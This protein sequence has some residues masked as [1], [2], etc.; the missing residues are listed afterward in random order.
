MDQIV[1]RGVSKSFFRAPEN[2]KKS[3]SQ[4]LEVLQNVNM[5]VEANEFVSVL[6]PSGCGKS[7]LLKII[8]GLDKHFAGQVE[9]D[10]RDVTKIRIPVRYM[11]QKDHLMPWRTLEQNVL[12]PV[13]LAKGNMS[14][15]RKQ[16]IT[17][18]EEFGLSGF[19]HY[20]PHE[21]SGGMKQR[22]ALLRTYLMQGDTMLLDEPFGALD[23]ITRMQMQDWLLKVWE[24]HRNTVVFVTH[25]IEEAVYLSD[26]VFVMSARPGCITRCINID[27]PRP[28]S[29]E[30][31]LETKFLD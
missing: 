16:L 10:G 17:H 26:K 11:L 22:A 19:E 31:L 14:E 28:R 30:M 29:R 25:A 23:E 21:L 4:L 12:L 5:T 2:K 1:V 20:K 6:G 8:A 9:I 13:E 7:T 24:H 15:A 27:F 3:D 18:L